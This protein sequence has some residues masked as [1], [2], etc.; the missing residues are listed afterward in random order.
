M[1]GGAARSS[2]DSEGAAIN[3]PATLGSTSAWD[4]PPASR[5]SKSDGRRGGPTD[6]ATWRSIEVISSA[7]VTPRRGPLSASVAGPDLE[8][9]T[10]N[11]LAPVGLTGVGLSDVLA[12]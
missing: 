8:W 7:K 4:P 6:P 12:Q 11:S 5:P 10:R 9:F 1:A 3:R 2:G